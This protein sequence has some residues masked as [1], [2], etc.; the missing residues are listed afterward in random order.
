M[1]RDITRIF[2]YRNSG[3]VQWSFVIF[4]F[5]WLRNMTENGQSEVKKTSVKEALGYQL[6]IFHWK[7]YLVSL[8]WIYWNDTLQDPSNC[9]ILVF[10]IYKIRISYY[11]LCLKVVKLLFQ[12]GL[13]WLN[14]VTI[15]PIQQRSSK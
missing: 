15:M 7:P 11:Y 13:I 6:I 12:I 10:V 8:I 5:N 3:S 4:I 2:Y 14:W 1:N 9:L